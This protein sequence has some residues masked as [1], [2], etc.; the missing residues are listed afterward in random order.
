MRTL[1]LGLT[2]A[3]LAACVSQPADPPVTKRVKVDASNIAEAQAAGYR[4]V[5]RN[6]Q[7]LYCHKEY[8]T[9]SRLKSQTSCL[10]VTQW[11]ELSQG[12]RDVINDMGRRAQTNGG[13]P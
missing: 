13:R 9:G 7:T 11:A 12:S 1:L 5:N 3:L 4:V 8:L 2:A 10:T 6:G